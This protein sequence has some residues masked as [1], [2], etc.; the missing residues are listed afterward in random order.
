VQGVGLDTFGVPQDRMGRHQLA[1]LV[2]LLEAREKDQNGTAHFVVVCLSDR[3]EEGQ[4]FDDELVVD[5]V[6]GFRRDQRGTCDAIP[7]LI[8]DSF[9][10]S[11]AQLSVL[12][13]KAAPASIPSPP[14]ASATSAPPTSSPSSVAS[15]TALAH[16]RHGLDRGQLGFDI[17]QE[18]V[19][20]G[21][22][23]SR[24]VD[25]RAVPKVLLKEVCLQCSAHQDQLQSLPPLQQLLHDD[26]KEVRMDVALDRVRGE[27]RKVAE[28]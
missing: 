7:I 14:Q 9:Q 28:S 6:L 2:D 3:D 13:S 16:A 21:K 22:R 20:D 17:L 4:Q 27:E 19:P 12:L 26:E 11:I 24:H 18:D 15:H 23:A 25:G 10:T 1:K 8:S 5:R